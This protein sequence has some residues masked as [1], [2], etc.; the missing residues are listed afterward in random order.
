MQFGPM[1]NSG[2]LFEEG[3]VEAPLDDSNT[4]CLS[5]SASDISSPVWEQWQEIDEEDAIA[6]EQ[7]PAAV[8][9]VLQCA[10]LPTQ[11]LGNMLE[12]GASRRNLSLCK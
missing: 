12:P 6:L 2:E 9:E 3:D 11:S 1:T 4:D 10:A 8:N 5:D 7:H